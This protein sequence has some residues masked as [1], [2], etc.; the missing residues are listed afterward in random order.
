MLH[1]QDRFRL[2]PPPRSPEASGAAGFVPLTAEQQLALLS[3]DR[4]AVAS[5]AVQLSAD[6]TAPQNDRATSSTTQP[7]LLVNE[8]MAGVLR[9]MRN[10]PLFD[11]ERYARDVERLPSPPTTTQFAPAYRFYEAEA[12]PRAQSLTP[13]QRNPIIF[14]RYGFSLHGDR[15]RDGLAEDDRLMLDGASTPGPTTHTPV[16]TI[17]HT[18]GLGDRNR[19]PSQGLEGLDRGEPQPG[20]AQQ[21]GSES[22]SSP[23]EENWSSLFSTIP[24]DDHLP[25]ASSSF[26]S[27][28]SGPLS[29]AS[30]SSNSQ[31][32]SPSTNLTAPSSRANSTDSFT[33]RIDRAHVLAAIE[34]GESTSTVPPNCPTD[35]PR[36]YP[37]TSNLRPRTSTRHPTVPSPLD[38]N[39]N[40]N[41]TSHPTSRRP[42]SRS[43]SRL[44]T[45]RTPISHGRIHRSRNTRASTPPG[46]STRRPHRTTSTR[47]PRSPYLIP[48]PNHNSHTTIENDP[49]HEATISAISSLRDD[50]S[51]DPIV[52]EAAET[53]AE[54]RD[55]RDRL[56]VHLNRFE[57]LDG[58]LNRMEESREVP[59]EMWVGA[60]LTPGLGLRGGIGGRIGGRRE[61]L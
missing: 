36:R 10:D 47:H 54:A 51:A 3:G 11:R 56:E 34:R 26:T 25:S 12:P 22:E 50:P 38:R 41:S 8:M 48:S 40:S 13:E 44:T 18:S 53:L 59:D 24:P 7:S 9:S 43:P 30:L 29:A 15:T 33:Q 45:T 55:A 28:A 27:S 37:H 52:H 42:R 6:S 4:E 57:H 61:R 35:P 2:P 32:R 21:E 19:S 58:I 16:L 31:R 39:S 49:L 46:T 23:T 1:H 17:N 60:G 5:A 20:G 14:Q